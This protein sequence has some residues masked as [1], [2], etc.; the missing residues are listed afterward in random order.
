M[1][2]GIVIDHHVLDD[3]SAGNSY[4]RRLIHGAV[5]GTM[6]V[7]IPRYVFVDLLDNN[8]SLAALLMG[9]EQM[10]P[11]RL[12]TGIDGP[13]YLRAIRNFAQPRQVK[14]PFVVPTVF[15]AIALEWPIVTSN[16]ACYTLLDNVEVYGY[17][18]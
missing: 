6:R 9:L 11:G 15:D 16:P 8:D 12:M 7:W 4:A 17:G 14:D 2:D 5:D 1:A 18:S 3:L 10:C 13:A